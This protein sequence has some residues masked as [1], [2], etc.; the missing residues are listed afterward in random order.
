MAEVQGAKVR[1]PCKRTQEA[2]RHPGPAFPEPA[3]TTQ[4]FPLSSRFSGPS[5]KGK[6]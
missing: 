2:V 5:K 1:E 4:V 3:A 6:S